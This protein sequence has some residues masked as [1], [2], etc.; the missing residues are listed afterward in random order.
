MYVNVKT[1]NLFT[2]EHLIRVPQTQAYREAQ[3]Q[4]NGYSSPT[5]ADALPDYL[6]SR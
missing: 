5:I 6:I 1:L 2:K 4:Y 3:T